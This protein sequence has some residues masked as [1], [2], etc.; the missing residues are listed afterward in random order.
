MSDIFDNLW[1]A[2]L[3]LLILSIIGLIGVFLLHPK[4]TVRYSLSTYND[5]T[6]VIVRE[7]E[8]APDDMNALREGTTYQ[9][10]LDLVTKL[11]Q[12]LE[13]SKK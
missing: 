6:P 10:A 5:G 2:L 3:M 9:E 12:E 13:N 7:I 1:Q 4:D 11:N 8:W